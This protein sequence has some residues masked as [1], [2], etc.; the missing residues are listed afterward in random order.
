MF[1]SGH[2]KDLNNNAPFNPAFSRLLKYLP[3]SLTQIA[4]SSPFLNTSLQI[5]TLLLVYIVLESLLKQA[6]QLPQSA[7]F[8]TFLT[9][10]IMGKFGVVKLLALVTILIISWKKGSLLSRWQTFQQSKLIRLFVVF[11]ALSLAWPLVTLGYNF[12]FDQ[13]YYLDRVLLLILVA[14]LWWR[15]MF[16]LPFLV[17]AMTIMWQLKQPNLGGSILAHKM[18]VFNVLILFAATFL[19]HVVSGYKK[20]QTFVFMTCCMVAS[21][22]WQPALAKLQLDWFNHGQ[23]NYMLMAANAHGWMSFL[24]SEQ[25]VSFAHHIAW[26]DW[27]MRIFVITVEAG[28]L[29][30]MLHHRVSK[31]LLMALCGFHLAVFTMLGFLFWTWILLDL[32]LLYLLIKGLP[33][34]HWLIYN[35]RHLA[36]SVVLIGLCTFWAKPPALG[37]FDTRLT[38]TYKI[39]VVDEFEH[40]FVLSP[41]F[42]APYEDVFTMASFHYL[43]EDHTVLVGPYGVTQSA[44]KVDALQFIFN[45]EELMALE[46][47]YDD[48]QFNPTRAETF[49][50]FVKQFIINHNSQVSSPI[51]LGYLAPPRQFWSYKEHEVKQ[52]NQKIKTVIV[53]EIT[54]L[55]NDVTLDVIRQKE[56][57]QLE[58]K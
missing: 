33:K 6:T 17:V 56:L 35:K 31:I 46:K 37:W 16:I 58:I 13:G 11:L 29:F 23:L 20:T 25:I 51:G 54:T 36:W 45:R 34:Q 50:H 27:P 49:Y 18:Q 44:E 1:T 22:Y 3:K 7:Y 12:Y 10:A 28:C 47:T 41:E 30:F 2:L 42:F 39:E 43:V 19:I 32:A 14:A 15:P 48:I 40:H 52:L 9:S 53:T 55:Y 26:L 57:R 4:T 21:A 24:T 5:V 38:Y 8:Q